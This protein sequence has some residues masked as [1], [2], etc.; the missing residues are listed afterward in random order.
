MP[1][2]ALAR[3]VLGLALPLSNKVGGGNSPLLGI[4]AEFA[5]HAVSF[6]ASG[7]PLL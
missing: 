2:V 4:S 1:L 5:T 6:G 7:L 3:S